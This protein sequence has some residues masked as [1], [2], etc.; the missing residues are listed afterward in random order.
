[1]TELEI[2]IV[3][4]TAKYRKPIDSGVVESILQLRIRIGT[5]LIMMMAP[6]N[7]T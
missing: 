7:Y 3:S 5:S 2:G 1:M 4:D 6:E